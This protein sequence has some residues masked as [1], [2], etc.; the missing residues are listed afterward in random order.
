MLLEK[1]WISLKE[2]PIA[3]PGNDSNTDYQNGSFFSVLRSA[4]GKFVDISVETFIKVFLV[5][6]LTYKLQ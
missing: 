4:Y 1:H 6:S 2:A 3:V 5:L